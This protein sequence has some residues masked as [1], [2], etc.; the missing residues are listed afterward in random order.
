MEVTCGNLLPSKLHMQRHRVGARGNATTFLLPWE[1][2]L[3]ELEN[4]DSKASLSGQGP[5]LP[6]T[7]KELQ[8]IVQVLLKTCDEDKRDNLKHFIHQA[9][10]NQEKVINCILAMKRRGHRAYVH[11]DEDQMRARA[12]ELPEQ[13]V[14]PEVISLLPNDNSF[15]KLRIQKHYCTLG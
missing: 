9:Q 6:R 5:E 13:G 12:Q 7:G 14:P 15:E 1:G 4:L 3:A 2:I 8:Y 11:V 10:V